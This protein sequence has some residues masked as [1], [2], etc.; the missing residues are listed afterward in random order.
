[1]LRDADVARLAVFFHI[2]VGEFLERYAETVRGK[3]RLRIADNRMCV[4]FAAGPRC[5]VHE[6]RP[7]ICRAWPFFRGNLVDEVSFSM[8]AEGCAGLRGA[9]SF[10]DFVRIGARYLLENDIYRCG[11]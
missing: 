10:K 4:F 9:A 2:P 1:M 6:A 7:D 5:G 8:A 11:A 3:H